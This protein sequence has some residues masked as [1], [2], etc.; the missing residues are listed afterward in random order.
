MRAFVTVGTTQF[1]SL[2]DAVVAEPV[3]EA[4]HRDGITELHIQHG[5]A[6]APEPATKIPD[7]LRI[8]TFDFKPSL[9]QEILNADLVIGHAGA[10]TILE[11]LEAGKPMIIV[12]NEELMHNHQIELAQAMA[13]SGHALCCN[14]K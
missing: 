11:T 12:V 5:R 4:L 10:G 2:T 1:Q 13:D 6:P 14:P 7:G 3:L 8:E 9:Q